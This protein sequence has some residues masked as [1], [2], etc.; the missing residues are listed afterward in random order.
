MFIKHHFFSSTIASVLCFK[1]I[2]QAFSNII[3]PFSVI[4]CTQVAYSKQFIL[5]MGLYRLWLRD[6]IY[7]HDLLSALPVYLLYSFYI[8]ILLYKLIFA[9]KLCSNIIKNNFCNIKLNITRLFSVTFYFLY[10]TKTNFYNTFTL[11]K[12]VFVI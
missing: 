7:S 5:I 6:A 12:L 10:I 4:S 8:N 2:K 9:K 1:L 11:R 3:C